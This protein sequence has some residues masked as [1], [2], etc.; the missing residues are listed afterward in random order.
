MSNDSPSFTLIII[1]V[2][3]IPPFRDVKDRDNFLIFKIVFILVE[4]G[5]AKP[6]LAKLYYCSRVM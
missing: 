5:R 3:Y 6:G 1:I 4:Q 2:P